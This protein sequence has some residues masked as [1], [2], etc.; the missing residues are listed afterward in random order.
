ME[1][2][3]EGCEPHGRGWRGEMNE[4]IRKREGGGGN[5][6]WDLEKERVVMRFGGGIGR[7]G[8]LIY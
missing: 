7:L 2:G 5:W 3:S 6:G 1:M 8:K 4:K